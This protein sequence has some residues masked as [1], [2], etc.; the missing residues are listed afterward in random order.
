MVPD[1]PALLSQSV[2]IGPVYIPAARPSTSSP[3]YNSYPSTLPPPPPPPLDYVAPMPLPQPTSSV[4]T[5]QVFLKKIIP[6]K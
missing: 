1:P 5:V 3:Y 2:D 6:K 4:Y